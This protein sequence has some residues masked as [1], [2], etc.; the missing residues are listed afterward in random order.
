MSR[1]EDLPKNGSYVHPCLEVIPR[2]EIEGHG[3]VATE[4]IPK[5]STVI[6]WNGFHLVTW[7]W[8]QGQGKDTQEDAIQLTDSLFGLGSPEKA[9]L[10]NHSCEPNCGM[11]GQVQVVAMR[12]IQQSEEVFIDYAMIDARPINDF[13]CSCGSSLCRGTI[14]GDD[15][16]RPELQERYKGYFSVY[17]QSVIGR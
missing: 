12:D 14:S 9:D 11:L 5:G 1:V 2:P 15:W 10:I 6:L 3:L 4:V 8:L 13:H 17:V 7:E 16:K